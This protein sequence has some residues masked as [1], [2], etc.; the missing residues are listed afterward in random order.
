[1]PAYAE[2][3]VAWS[4]EPS[5]W[6]AAAVA[7]GLYLRGYAALARRSPGRLPA[8]RMVAFLGGVSVVLVALTSPI[9]PLADELLSVH[10][11]QHL[12]LMGVAPP[13]LWMGCPLVPWLLGLAPGP[14]RA[15]ARLAGRPGWRRLGRIATH[16]VTCWL[17][18]VVA[19]W[20]WHEPSLYER[21]LADER[22][23]DAEHL[24][25][26]AG[27]LA[28]WW[29]VVQP[30]PSRA[31]WPG[32]AMLLYL[33]LC[34]L[35]N[36]VFSAVFTFADHVIY[37]HYAVTALEHGLDPLADQALAGAV[38]WIPGSLL[39]LVPAL[40][41]ALQIVEGPRRSSA[42]RPRA[43]VHSAGALRS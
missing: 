13:L 37:P 17:A 5:L 1:M 11:S 34:A 22:W 35:Q 24:C 30:W 36:T 12:L 33:M 21:A 8:W 31:R 9:D 6:L 16:P 10:M 32:A 42:T 14:R 29:P 18:F 3:H 2:A 23:H 43:I 20:I 38:M 19:L 25:F 40:R 15:L 4:P 39:M 26:L 41:L 7:C 28:F 27:G